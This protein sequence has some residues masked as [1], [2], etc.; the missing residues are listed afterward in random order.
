M[1]RTAGTGS[2]S[3]PPFGR[4]ITLASVCVIIAAL[5]FAQDVLIPLAL[6][7]L[8]SFL[9]APLVRRL[10][11]WRVP[12]VPSVIIVVTVALGLIVA[13]GYIVWNQ[14]IDLTK[15]LPRYEANIEMKVERLRPSGEGLI[16]KWRKAAEDINKAVVQAPATS[17]ATSQPS[18]GGHPAPNP[19][20]LVAG[21]RTPIEPSVPPSSQPAGTERNPMWVITSPQPRTPIEILQTTLGPLV[22]PLGTAGIVIVFTIFMLLAR[23]DM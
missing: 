1:P 20:P 19:A 23:E 21:N 15:N 22:S 13:M 3:A 4:F 9:L 2:T 16:G 5:Y 17:Q 6:A 11:R 7:M 10:E 8:L 14:V 18:V 12:R